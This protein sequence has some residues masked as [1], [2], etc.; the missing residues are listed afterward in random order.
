MVEIFNEKHTEALALCDRAIDLIENHD[1]HM[2]AIRILKQAYELYPTSAKIN[3]WLGFMYGVYEKDVAQ[4]L[5]MCKK[6]IQEGEPDPLFFRNIGKL[7]I[8]QNN[9]RAAIGAFARGLQIDEF[10]R[11]ILREWSILGFRRRPV[12]PFLP[13]EFFL[14]KWLGLLTWKFSPKNP[15]KGKEEPAK[16]GR[17]K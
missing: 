6:A 1:D 12:I 8:L 9:K 13:R 15:N 5:R 2:T 4:G 3:S 16:K 11:E 7:Y 14:N 10:N 17:R